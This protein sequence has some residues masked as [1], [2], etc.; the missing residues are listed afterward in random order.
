V[1]GRAIRFD[2]STE[3]PRGFRLRMNDSALLFMTVGTACRSGSPD[4]LAVQIMALRARDVHTR[5]VNLVPVREPRA[6][7]DERDGQLGGLGGI[8]ARSK[9][10]QRPRHYCEQR[11]TKRM[12]HPQ[13]HHIEYSHVQR[14]VNDRR[15]ICA[16][17]LRP[18]AN[19]A[20]RVRL[21]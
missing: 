5:D 19:F 10:R 17:H 8:R 15:R 16:A 9:C 12:A 14:L 1:A 20:C 2:T 13:R 18:C 7:P 6:L 3:A 4:R 11:N 21:E